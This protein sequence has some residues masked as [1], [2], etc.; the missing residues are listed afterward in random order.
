MSRTLL[1]DINGWS[2]I[3]DDVWAKAQ[4]GQV[5]GL[6]FIDPRNDAGPNYVELAPGE[7]RN[8]GDA[9]R[10]VLTN[11][12][13]MPDWWFMIADRNSATPGADYSNCVWADGYTLPR[14]KKANRLHIWVKFP[15]GFREDLSALT[16]LQENYHV[17][18]YN[19]NPGEIDGTRWVVEWGGIH[20]YHHIIIR[21]DLAQDNWV[22]V[23][24]N[25]SAHHVRQFSHATSLPASNYMKPHGGHMNT[26]TRW[27]FSPIPYGMFGSPASLT[28]QAEIPAPYEILIDS[29]YM[30]W[31]DEVYSVRIQIENWEQGQC[32][33]VASGATS[34][35]YDVAVT[36]LTSIPVTGT[37]RIRNTYGYEMAASL[38]LPSTSTNIDN[39]QIT[40]AANETK[41]Y[42]L[43]FTPPDSRIRDNYV[44]EFL[45]EV[46]N[47]TG[48]TFTVT[49]TNTGGGGPLTTAPIAYNA[50]RAQMESALETTTGTGWKVV[51][52]VGNYMCF[53][54][55]AYFYVTMTSSVTGSGAQARLRFSHL[56]ISIDF[57]DLAQEVNGRYHGYQI[58]SKTD[59]YVAQPSNMKGNL[60]PP[61]GDICSAIFVGNFWDVAPT[62]AYAPHTNDGG[63]SGRCFINGAFSKQLHSSDVDGRAVTFELYDY[64]AAQD[65]S[66]VWESNPG[67]VTLSSGG[68][69]SYTPPSDWSGVVQVRYYLNNGVRK[70]R[71]YTYFIWVSPTNFSVP[72]STSSKIMLNPNG[73][74]A[75][76]S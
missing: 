20:L 14:G 59:P 53:S 35:R 75:T 19:F 55:N 29:V 7:G 4:G 42:E 65:G 41:N 43:Q 57:Y 45:V 12:G 46:L 54:D 60:G 66:M 39:T 26:L 22:H 23:C 5:R 34:S 50:T 2:E 70:S 69:L 11:S 30:D 32:V 64:N 51:G 16:N 33:D 38:F 18:T 52:S 58:I 62:G 17:G 72:I 63:E 9:I 56:P 61:D 48:G 1:W 47:A 40:L 49:L 15:A 67:G 21:H 71:L 37:I 68:L 6:K 8:G 36:N 44:S 73:T 74:L 3:H 76:I 27:Y 28:P 25:Q 24:V 31:V 10:M 13:S